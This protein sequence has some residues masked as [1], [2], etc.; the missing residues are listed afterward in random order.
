MSKYLHRAKR[1][2]D[3]IRNILVKELDPIGIADVE[4]ARDEYD[5]YIS[6]LYKRLISRASEKD[7]FDYL[8]T[9]ET[10]TMGL[11]GN[12][13]HTESIVHRLMSLIREIEG[14]DHTAAG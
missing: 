1:Y 6:G 7:L 3:H 4:E 2:H 13:S 10:E 8:W 14:E 5:A 11:K 9:I 12:R